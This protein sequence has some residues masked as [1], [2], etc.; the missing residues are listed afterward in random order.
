MHRSQARRIKRTCWIELAETRC[1]LERR[2]E[3]ERD[4]GSGLTAVPSTSR[5]GPLESPVKSENQNCGLF[6]AAKHH[7]GWSDVDCNTSLDF[8]CTRTVC[9]GII[10]TL[11]PFI[12][13]AFDQRCMQHQRGLRLQVMDPT[14]MILA[15][16]PA[17]LS[18][19]EMVT[20]ATSGV[21]R[22]WTGLRLRRIAGAWMAT[23]PRSPL[24]MSM[25][26]YN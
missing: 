6:R 24:K 9:T 4:S 23:L 21:R 16:S 5:A 2:T 12:N 13:P 19:R 25:T 1:G 14:A 3:R 7:K 15:L 26:T 20:A 17:L 8:V 10:R 11:T 18:G 22:S